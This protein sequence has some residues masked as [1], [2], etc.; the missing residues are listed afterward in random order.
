MRVCVFLGFSD[1][2]EEL[3]DCI[4]ELGEIVKLVCRVT[5]IFKFVVSWYKGRF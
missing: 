2:E 4:V 1:F 5:G 3:V